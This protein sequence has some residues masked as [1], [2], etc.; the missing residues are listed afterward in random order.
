MRAAVVV[1][2]DPI[3]DDAD[4]ML[5]ALEALA[6]NA[7]FLEC[8]D[9]RATAA[10]ATAVFSQGSGPRTIRR[11]QGAEQDHLRQALWAA[12][13]GCTSV[14]GPYKTLYNQFARWSRMD[15]CRA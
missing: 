15:G 2:A 14:Y 12:M 3:T 5:D 11:L 6:M 1:E 9:E 10:A 8:G 13:A 4:R 7:L